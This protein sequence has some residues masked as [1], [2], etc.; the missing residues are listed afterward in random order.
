[1]RCNLIRILLFG[2]AVSIVAPVS[3]E[4][5]TPWWSQD[6]TECDRQSSHGLDPFHVAP[7][8]TSKTMD[9]AKAQAAC[10]AAVAADPDN[11]RLN[12]QLGRVYGYSG[13]WQKAMPYRLKAVEA[14][15]PQSLFVIGYLYFSGNTIDE[16]NPCKT[17]KMWRRGAELGRL[18]A[19]VALPRH[20]MRGDFESC[21]VKIPES[22]LAGYLDAAE[23]QTGDFYTSMLIEDLRAELNQ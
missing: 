12:Y 11:P 2:L 7:P 9:F 13:Q 8:V 16:K 15:Y 19:Q 10:E 3:A 18:A 4:T 20:Y 14:E 21:G 1:M 6:V 22:E 5:I 17:V 23:A